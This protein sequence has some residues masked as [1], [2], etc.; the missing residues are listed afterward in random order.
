MHRHVGIWLD[1]RKAYIV[2][3]HKEAV[4]TTSILSAVDDFHAVGG[5]RSS[6]P[7]G[8]QDAV[9]ESKVLERRKQQLKNYYCRLAESIKAADAIY[10][11]GPAEAKYGFEKILKEKMNLGHKIT[12]VESAD[13]MTENQIVA[14]V[15]SH[16]NRLQTQ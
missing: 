16:F 7:Y 13:S 11:M 15:K 12:T 3:L 5:S 1:K 8:P 4:T 2:H 6:T 14:K 10:I 9:S